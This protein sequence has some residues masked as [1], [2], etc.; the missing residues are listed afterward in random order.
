MSDRAQARAWA[1]GLRLSL[2]PWDGTLTP[3][4]ERAL[5]DGIA[6]G[7]DGPLPQPAPGTRCFA[8]REEGHT[9]GLLAVRDGCPHAGAATVVA[10]AIDPQ[11]RGRAAGARAL[12]V[13]ERRLRREG[14]R[15]FF[16]LV[17][18]GNGRG[19]YFMLRAGYVP[20]GAPAS[21]HGVDAATWFQRHEQDHGPGRDAPGSRA[22]RPPGGRRRLAT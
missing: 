17:P 20:S 9:S 14:V 3:G 8:V 19:L 7:H 22:Q 15:E 21:G 6:R 5:R 12:L 13:A 4:V 16:A 10:I 11:H 1:R 18:R 2:R